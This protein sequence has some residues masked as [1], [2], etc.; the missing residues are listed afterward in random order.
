MSLQAALDAAI[1]AARIAGSMLRTE[2]NRPEGPRREGPAKAPID[3]EVERFLHEQLAPVN[4]AWGWESEEDPALQRI[5]DTRWVIDPNDGTMHYLRGHRGAAVSI[6]LIR[7]N[8]PVL[9]VIYAYCAPDEHG[10]LFAW[11]EDC[12][13][14]TRNGRQLPPMSDEPLM[15]GAVVLVSPSADRCPEANAREIH[16]ARF[17]TCASLAYRLARVA[18]GDAMGASA[19][20]GPRR[21][22]YAAGLGLLRALGGTLVDGNGSSIQLDTPGSDVCFAG[23]WSAVAAL[24]RGSERDFSTTTDPLSVP[25]LPRI[26]DQGILDRA[27]GCWLAQLA[28]DSLGSLVEFQSPAS[29]TRKYPEGVRDLADGGTFNTIAGQPTDDSE[30]ALAMARS[31]IRE[32]AYD[33]EKVAHAYVDWYESRPFDIGNTVGAATRAGLAARKRGESLIPAIRSASSQGSQANG[34][35]MRLAPLAIYGVYRSPDVIAH[36]ARAD[37]M[38]SHPHAACQDANVVFA[39]TI[40]HAIRVGPSREAIYEFAVQL[41]N[42]IRAHDVVRSALADAAHGPPADFMHQM[43]WLRLA[44][45]NAFHQLLHSESLEEGLSDTVGR[46]GDTDTNA[47]IAG[48]LLGAAFGRRAVPWRWQRAVLSCRPMDGFNDVR[49]PRPSWLWPADAEVLAERLLQT[50]RSAN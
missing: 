28:G 14:P 48:A 41:A 1:H 7:D 30:M 20:S 21:H 45:Q 11:A 9:S 31:I 42:E 40:A 49:R 27:L 18:A 15:P 34:S 10:D 24:A 25:R 8:Q 46:G 12:G 16:P 43:G 5:E 13:P 44:L 23:S 4:P 33:P 35:L 38:L 39:C 6:A 22:D 26:E 47:C 36:D 19:Y 50:G 37:A 32:G 2:M 3:L 17:V 29:I